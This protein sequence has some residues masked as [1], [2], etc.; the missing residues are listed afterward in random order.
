MTFASTIFDHKRI[1]RDASRYPD[2]GTVRRSE[3]A[4]LDAKHLTEVTGIKCCEW[5]ELG[6]WPSRWCARNTGR[7]WGEFPFYTSFPHW[8]VNKWVIQARL[9]V[10]KW[11]RWFTSW[12]GAMQ[13]IL[14]LYSL[15]QHKWE[16][17]MIRVHAPGEIIRGT[18]YPWL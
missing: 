12:S 7:S 9:C 2:I 11:V 18:V 17:W 3:C 5:P 1:F 14:I 8:N 13:F 10:Y 15:S 4:R 6:L 16:L